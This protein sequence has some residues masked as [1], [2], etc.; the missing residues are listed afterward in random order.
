MYFIDKI[1]YQIERKK[2]KKHAYIF[3]TRVRHVMAEITQGLVPYSLSNQKHSLVNIIRKAMMK[4]V[5]KLQLISY[6]S[7]NFGPTTN[8]S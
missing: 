5:S 6:V 3:K 7:E 1:P 2:Q 8:F 4:K